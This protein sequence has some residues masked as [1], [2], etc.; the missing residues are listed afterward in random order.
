MLDAE[1]QV[2]RAARDGGQI[3]EEVLRRAQRDM[4]LEESMLSRTDRRMSE[5]G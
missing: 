1:R 4:D 2:F 3:A 5:D